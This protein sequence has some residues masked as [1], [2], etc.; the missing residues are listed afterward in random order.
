MHLQVKNH[1]CTQI[2]A[3]GLHIL[4]THL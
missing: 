3:L 2:E 4:P 1:L